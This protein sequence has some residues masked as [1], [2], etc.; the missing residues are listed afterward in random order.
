MFQQPE[1][2]SIVVVVVSEGLA[3]DNHISDDKVDF[4]PEGLV[5]FDEPFVVLDKFEVFV[6]GLR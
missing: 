6:Q 3:Q 1:F 2:S 5:A 4:L